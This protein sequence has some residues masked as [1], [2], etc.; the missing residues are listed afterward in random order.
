M[1]HPDRFSCVVVGSQ[2]LLIECAEI[3][4][5][6]SH[7]I[8]GIVS[9]DPAVL[10]WAD[11]THTDLDERRTAALAGYLDQAGFQAL[12]A[13]SKETLADGLGVPCVRFRIDDGVARAA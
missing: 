1:T 6:G 2:A 11:R 13:T 3:L 10:R 7:E 5:R 9:S 4:L 12:V 8:R